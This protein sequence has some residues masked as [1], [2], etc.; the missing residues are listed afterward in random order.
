MKLAGPWKRALGVAA[1]VASVWAIGGAGSASAAGEIGEVGWWTRNPLSTAPDGG[2]AV[3]AA[4]DGVTAVAALRIDVGGGVETLVLEV[5]PAGDTV[6]LSSLEVC[7]APE[8]WTAAAPGPLDDA[9]ATACEGDSVPF[10]EAGDQWRADVSSL[11]QST[12]GSVSL[13]VVP[14]AGSGTVPYEVTFERPSARATGA[15]AAPAP[16]GA[17]TPSPTPAPPPPPSATPSVN[18][19]PAPPTISVGPTSPRPAVTVPPAA[20]AA[21]TA[22]AETPVPPAEQDDASSTIE[23]ASAGLLDDVASSEPR[24]GEALVLVLI[25]LVVGAAVYGISRI[26]ASRAAGA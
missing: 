23:L 10:A 7:V 20:P 14:I 11:V 24:W 15:T 1:V 17:P 22:P 8:T 21:P 25:G 2:F 3:G 18:R 6:A 13:A 26:S 5:Q 19:A 16:R 9:P 4:P 12:S